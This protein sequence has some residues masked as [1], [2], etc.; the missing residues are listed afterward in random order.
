MLAL[1]LIAV[2]ASA[3]AQQPSERAAATNQ[4]LTKTTAKKRIGARVLRSGASGANVR[5]LQSQLTVTGLPVP[6]TG[7]YRTRTA[8]A[9]RRFQIAAGMKASGVAGPKTL[10]ALRS[11]VAG[12]RSVD[13]GGGLGFGDDS[14]DTRRLGSRIPLATGMSG[15][16]VRQL[17]D[18]LRRA[19][20]KSARKPHGEFD[21]E[22]AS[23]VRRFEQRLKR[24]VDGEFDAGDIYALLKKIGKDAQAGD[25]D[26]PSATLEEAP[27]APGDR[28]KL[29]PDGRAIAPANAPDAVKQIIAAGNRI[30]T[31]PY[32]WGGGHGRWEDTGYDCSGSVSY[33]LRG[34]KLLNSPLPSYGFFDW[35]EPGKGR[36]VTVYTN[37][38]HMY[39]VVAGLRFDTSGRKGTG[40]R[41]QTATRDPARYKVRHPAGL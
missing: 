32:L 18:Y 21:S 39:M 16:D 24:P 11:A 17:Q 9:V 6:V 40:S 1:A 30:A 36:W 34:A 37:S 15:R 29:G 22:T 23:T 14:T 2:P 3:S 5:I 19:R 10:S 26:D 31:K 38:G 7:T 8:R 33:A 13:A 28:A 27:L 12:P 41:W 35:A 20:V 4:A 25:S